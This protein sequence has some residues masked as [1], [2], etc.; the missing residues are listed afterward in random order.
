MGSHYRPIFLKFPRHSFR[1]VWQ[2]DVGRSVR[3]V[4]R[5]CAYTREDR[6]HK[7]F[8]VFPSEVNFPEKH[9]PISFREFSAPVRNLSKAPSAGMICRGCCPEDERAGGCYRTDRGRRLQI[10]FPSR[11]EFPRNRVK[12]G[13]LLDHYLTIASFYPSE[14]SVKG[15]KTKERRKTENRTGDIDTND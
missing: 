3:S 4:S 2:V 5:P 6:I 8:S 14:T 12:F 13:N 1:T 11:L 10:M 7:I 15:R 9:L